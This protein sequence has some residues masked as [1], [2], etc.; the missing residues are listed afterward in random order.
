MKAVIL[1]AVLALLT[2]C[3]YPQD[4][5]DAQ[6]GPNEEQLERVQNAVTQFQENTGVLPIATREADTPQYRRYPVQFTQLIPAYLNEPPANAFENGGTYQ[7]VLMNVEETPEVKLIDLRTVRTIQELE[8]QIF[9]Y[10]SSNQYA[11]VD[12]VVGSELLRLDYEALGYEEEPTVASPF[13][14]DHRLPLLYTTQGDVVIDFSLDI[15]HYAE[16]YGLDGYEYGEDMRDLLTDHAP[17]VPAYSVPTTLTEEGGTEF[18]EGEL[19]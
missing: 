13:H 6:H 19:S 9:S 18:L 14:P 2:G 11:P 4:Q 17:F 16:E 7:Y 1:L 12:E 15:Q 3:L 8:T 10:R 5:R